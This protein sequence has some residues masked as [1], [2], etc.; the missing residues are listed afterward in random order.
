M[1]EGKRLYIDYGKCIGCE[2]CEAVCRLLHGLPRINM[3]RTIDGVMMP[4]YCR[5]CERPACV[6]A[7]PRRALAKA[8][9]GAV[10]L[11]PLVCE[12]CETKDCI[13]AC[14]FGGVFMRD[15]KSAVV[16]CDMCADRRA[17]G[18]GPACVEMCPTE[19]LVYIERDEIKKL[20]TE[21][22]VAAEKK[23]F[24]HLRPRIQSMPG[25]D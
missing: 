21:E 2:T 19:A 13:E 3:T 18:L 15:M 25:K 23:V 4:L 22:S 12:G 11:Q 16:K 1:P 5:H 6:K 17:I 7:C 14:P 10:L 20:K 24:D 8:V 9:D